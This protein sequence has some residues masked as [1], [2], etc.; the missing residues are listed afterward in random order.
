[1][2]RYLK[3]FVLFLVVLVVISTGVGWY[4]SQDEA[5][6]KSQLRS[7]TLKYTGRDLTLNGPVQLNLGRVTTLEAQDVHFANAAWADQPD[8]VTAGHL[9]ISID[10]SSLFDDQIVFPAVSLEDVKVRLVRNEQGE[11]NWDMSPE[12]KPKAGPSPPPPRRENLPVVFRDLKISNSEIYLA[13]LKL[14]DP[15]DIRISQLAMQ[16]LEND[17]W[18]SKIAG[19]LNE[20]PLSLDGWFAPFDALILGGPLDHDLNIGLG[21][22]SLQSSGSLKDV[23]TGEGA[24]LTTSIQGPDIEMLLLEFKLPPFSQGAFDYQ[25]KLNTEGNMTKLDLDGDLGSVDIKA[26][27]ELDQLLN[28]SDGNVQLSIDGPNLGALAKVFGV[29]GVVEDAFSHISH[30]TFKKDAIHFNKASL[31]TDS[32]QLEI[33]GHFNTG[34]SF[35][36]TELTVRFQT[37]EAGRWTT[38]FGQPQQDIGPLE[39]DASLNSDSSGLMSIK[40]KVTQGPTI[41]DVEGAL[42]QLPDA[43]QPD[44]QVVFNSPDSSH[45]AAI[46]GYQMIPATPLAI[47]GRFG[48]RDN[49]IQLGKVRVDLAGN[50]TDL[51]GTIN[52]SDHYAGSKLNLQVDVKNAGDLG[53]LFGQEGIPEQP[54]KLVAELKPEGNGLAFKVTDGNLGDIQLELDG[55]IPDLEQPL[56]MDG[57]FDIKLPRLNYVTLFFPKIKLPDAPFSARG[58]LESKDRSVQID[59]VHIDLAGDKATINGLLKLD[60]HYAGSDLH[61]ALDIKNVAALGRLFGQ[62]G[63]PA[64]PTKMTLDVT[65]SGEGMA[66]EL[67][68]SKLGAIRADLQGKIADMSQPLAM[69]ADFD[70][71]LPRLSDIDLL[72]PQMKLPNAPFSARGALRS[73][74]KGVQLNNVI[75]KLAADQAKVNGLLKLENRYAG[76]NLSAELDIKNAATLGRLF[77]KD[78]LPDEPF[79]V[80]LEVKPNG[81]GMAFKLNDGNVRDVQVAIKGQIADL[82]HPMI[83]D[84]EF[85]IQLSK[86]SE[87]S[88]LFPEKDLPDTSFT[89]KGRLRNQKTRTHVEQAYLELGEIKASVDGDLLANNRFNLSIKASGL[90]A[91]TLTEIIGQPMPAEAFSVSTQL[92]GSPAELSFTNLDVKLGKSQAAGELTVGLGDTTRIRGQITSPHLDLSYWMPQKD[93][94]EAAPEPK[95]KK[96]WMFD[97]TPTMDWMPQGLNVETHIQVNKLTMSNT[98]LSDFELSLRLHDQFLRVKP[99]SY[100]GQQG[101][102]YVAEIQLDGRG[103][104][105]KIHFTANGKDIRA[106]FLSAPGQDPSSY[107]PVETEM[108]LDGRG[109]TRREMAS[110]LNGRTRIYLGSGKIANAGLDLFFSDFLTQLISTL[111][112][113][114]K[115]SEYTQLDCAVMA[116]EAES[117]VVTVFPVIYQTEHLTILSE[118]TVDLNTEKIDLAFN[119]KP[120]KGI[121]LNAGTLINPLI[122][123]GGRLTAPAVQIDAAGGITSGGL[124]VATLGISVLAKSFSDRFLSAQDPCGEARKELEK[125]D[126]QKK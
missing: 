39:L 100:Q 92:T 81:K 2:R 9:K 14:E 110:S 49:Q 8:M 38:V 114:S 120:R 116:A 30:T 51:D 107:P 76:S 18:Q 102:R 27:G 71:Q 47:Q 15:L 31:K 78:G 108:T 52:L 32:D 89:A 126:S 85:D 118:G 117:G 87:I 36:G 46:A 106:G 90:D 64:Q 58:K 55:R 115:N 91:S 75:I 33:G 54:V 25:L 21:K 88:F 62:D 37:D 26:T 3:F 12:K 83:M 45:L 13:S 40:A 94:E 23:R 11:P 121:G 59:N 16:H 6:L 74:D 69:D 125:R 98:T 122:K 95:N 103:S 99:I 109:A 7:Q 65:P 24:N 57:N 105:P 61:A 70:I 93:A 68:D 44:L 5:F 80:N 19:S 119:T 79:K 111:N 42:G 101:G 96:Q 29:E 84:A 34:A 50:L 112:P 41:L 124:A 97:D 86:L 67:H 35:S 82:N 113:F 56:M 28:P 1:M 43:L 53:R 20:L 22:I 48:Y 60:N 17:R 123:V 10:L 77:G 4:L 73:R 72:V 104:K 63:L 66:F